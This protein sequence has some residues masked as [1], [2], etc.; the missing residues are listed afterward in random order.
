M[1]VD[2]TASSP[3]RPTTTASARSGRASPIGRTRTAPARASSELR[4]GRRLVLAASR[5]ATSTPTAQLA[6]R[7]D[8]DAVIHLGDYIYEYGAGEYG[9]RARRTSRR[10]RSSR[11]S[12]YRTR[13]AQYRRD[14]TCRRCTGSYPFIAVWD[15][16]EVGEQRLARRRREPPARATEGPWAERAQAA[17]ARLLRV[18]ADPRPARTAGSS[19]RFASATW[20]TRSCSTRGSGGATARRR[21]SADLA[22]INDPN[23]THARLRPGGRGSTSSCA[24]RPR[25]WRII[26][27]QVMLRPLKA[28]GAPNSEG[29]GTIVNPTSGTATPPRASASSSH[30]RRGAAATSW[31]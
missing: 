8:L 20:S 23:R 1:K 19:A 21:D 24:P 25:H 26:G 10:T 16:H 7:D 9:E 18:D 27:Q 30:P 17:R 13:Y 5:T 6:A 14:P 29:G 15:D 22:V 3:A 28:P 2:A 4:F 11:S 12:D 31:S